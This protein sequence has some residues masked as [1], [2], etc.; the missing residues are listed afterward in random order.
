MAATPVSPLGPMSETSTRRLLVNLIG[1]LSLS[2]PDYDFTTLKP[3]DFLRLRSAREAAAA[4]NAKMASIEAAEGTGFL[5]SMWDTIDEV[6]KLNECEVYSYIPEVDDD[7][8]LGEDGLWSFNY[9]FYNKAQKQ[10]LYITCVGSYPGDED[11]AAADAEMGDERGRDGEAEA[12]GET[13][14][15]DG[16]FGGS[17]GGAVQAAVEAGE[18]D[19]PDVEAGALGWEDGAS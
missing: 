13:E 18:R 6:I 5:N 9:F 16:G 4:A 19:G 17:Y 14:V 7:P 3:D 15:G 10:I 11:G 12:D 2:F 1:T 8:L